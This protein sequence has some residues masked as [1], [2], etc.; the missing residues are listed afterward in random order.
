MHKD[1]NLDFGLA[2]WPALCIWSC[3]FEIWTIFP[4]LHIGV[5]LNIGWPL[6][7]L[8][9][10][11]LVF[12][13]ETT[14]KYN[15]HFVCMQTS[16]FAMADLDMLTYF[17]CWSFRPETWTMRSVLKVHVITF[18]DIIIKGTQMN[19][20]GPSWPSCFPFWADCSTITKSETINSL[21]LFYIKSLVW[22]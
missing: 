14:C 7:H 6:P 12:K 20:K 16:T 21:I 5:N 10:Y 3:I 11:F 2:Y 1:L 18:A 13:I 19:N 15:Y 9:T 17:S 4:V 22:K 8:Q